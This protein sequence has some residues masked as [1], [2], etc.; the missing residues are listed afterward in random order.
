VVDIKDALDALDQL[1]I[2]TVKYAIAIR[3]AERLKIN[4]KEDQNRREEPRTLINGFDAQAKYQKAA[5]DE[6]RASQD[7]H[8]IISALRVYADFARKNR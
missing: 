7:V 1:Q 5:E 6:K 2:A 4:F 8:M 3:V